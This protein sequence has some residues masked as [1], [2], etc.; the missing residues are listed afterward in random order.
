MRALVSTSLRFRYV[1]LALAGAM[2]FFGVGQIHS[3]PVDVFPEFAP[4]RVEI[5]TICL[6]LSAAEV[7]SL[8]SV[9]MEQSLNG[10][11]N[12]DRM[13]SKSVPQLSSIE[14]IFKQGTDLLNARQVVQERVATIVPTL[15]TW[16]APPVMIQPVSAT[17]RVMKVGISS[18]TVSVMDMSMI[19]YWKIRARLLRV[20]GVA[21]VAIWGE[22]LKMLQVQTDPVRLRENKVTLEQ[23]MTA[24]ADALDVGLLKFSE[25]GGVIG[26]G[27]AVDTPNQQL[28]LRPVL[29]I[30]TA[31]DMGKV[32]V[33]TKPDGS[34]LVL[35][36]VANLVYD[37]QP[38]FGD[39]VVNDDR[40][41]MLVVQK[42]PWGN[43]LEVTR[44]VQQALDELKPS[45]PDMQI[46]PTI[47][48]SAD[49]IDLAV[50]NLARALLIGTLLVIVILILFLFSWRSALIS[51]IAIPLS[52][53]A[54]LLV[55]HA[56]H[57]TINT[58]ILAGL[59][60]AVGVVVDDAIID[61]ENILRRLRQNRKEGGTQSTASIILEGS[62]E[63]R[64]AIVYATLIDVMTLVPVL[65]MKGLSGSFFRPLAVSYGLAV[66]ASMFVALTVT[67]AL[68]MILLSRAHI[69]RHESPLVRWLHRRYEAT[70]G[71]IIRTPR[72]AFAAVGAVVLLGALVVPRLG[73]SL[74]PQFKER[75][76]L[77]HWITKPGTSD[78]EE[79][80]MVQR[81]SKELRQIPGVRNFGSHI[82]QAFLAEEVAGV[83]FG[84]NWISV[85]SSVDYDK[86]VA[87]IQ[88]VIDGYPGLFH[89][90]QTYLNERI[91]E[92][93]AGAS[94]PIV[95]RV[96][97]ADLNQLRDTAAEVEHTVAGIK[98]VEDAHTE[99]QE[100]VPQVRVEVDL[101]AAQRYGIK[102]GDVRRDAATLVAGE[103]V[104]DLFRDGQAYDVQVWSTPATRQNLTDIENLPIDTPRDGQIRLADVAKVSVQPTPNVV[105]REANSRSIDVDVDVKGRGLSAV[106]HDVDTKLAALNMPL[107]YHTE[108]LGEYAERQATQSRLLL[109]AL[110]AGVGVLLLLWAA[111]HSIRLALLS[112]FTLP[113]ALVG[114]LIAGYLNGGIISL[115]AL[116]GFFTILGIAARNGIMLINHY[117]HLERFEGE[118]F[119]PA[120]IVRGARER[121]APILM[122]ALATGLAVIPLVVA[123]NIPGHEIEHPM[124]VIIVGGLVT[125]TLL[126][127]FIVPSLYLR[128]GR[129]RDDETRKEGI[130]SEE[131]PPALELADQR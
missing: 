59:V 5:Q 13:R 62:L 76:F 31:E 67:P 64:S 36:D 118:S 7:E 38:L 68:G 53:L 61:I 10:L 123:G 24:T 92:V 105:H 122:T 113:S 47:F 126:N 27:G 52:L 12:L 75:D 80:R 19:A 81:I 33:G 51:V 127:L 110:V 60:I 96:F 49:F 74:F 112:F 100:D 37:H 86:T 89:N 129:P 73:S 42:L 20:P 99:L 131:L 120:M 72:P 22:Q 128:F 29:P 85:D 109:F 82:G 130:A 107:G 58:M 2:V 23:V 46:D 8:V 14:L 103:E 63:V 77:I 43:T 66:L 79:V 102:P 87:K 97:G 71:R 25:G 117:Q 101:A 1:V 88:A 115:G 121:L 93:L 125:S 15:P 70:L 26:R 28:T 57:Q 34:P 94:S 111:F 3:M 6:G 98:G 32:S 116:I 124:A 40:G 91:E 44:G 9:P 55:L 45:L 30:V 4:P 21:D 56:R 108:V 41:L 48:R 84:E 69:E 17:S 90:V 18:K 16:A 104:G 114:G 65:F 83:N 95:V 106:A 54:A 39:A 35:N 78:Q 11:P 50:H 119:G